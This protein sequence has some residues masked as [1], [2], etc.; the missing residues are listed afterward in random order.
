MATQC[1]VIGDQ[2]ASQAKKLIK[3]ELLLD[4]EVGDSGIVGAASV[5]KDYDFVELI[6]KSESHEF[7]DLMFAYN[8]SK[9]CD[10]VLYLGHWNDGF[11]E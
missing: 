4:S 11:V 6:S 7:Y 10:G 8:G 9:L 1:I 5:P 2:Q 3:F